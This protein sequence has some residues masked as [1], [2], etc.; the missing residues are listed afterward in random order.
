MLA[1]PEEYLITYQNSSIQVL[2]KRHPLA[3]RRRSLPVPTELVDMVKEDIPKE[4]MPEYIKAVYLFKVP[5]YTVAQSKVYVDILLHHGA[6][7]AEALFTALLVA[8]KLHH[9]MVIRNAIWS[10]HTPIDNATLN[11]WERVLY[12]HMDYKVYL[13]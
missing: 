1:R 4:F 3:R 7:M 13:K 8:H 6:S 11:K 9:D 10:K 2:P 5:K 12:A